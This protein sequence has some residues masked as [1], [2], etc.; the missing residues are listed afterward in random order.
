MSSNLHPIFEQLL[1]PIEPPHT[2]ERLKV[3]ATINKA[4]DMH[5]PDAGEAMDLIDAIAA[6]LQKRYGEAALEAAL[7]ASHL[8]KA[9][10][11]L[12][13]G[14]QTTFEQSEVDET[15]LDRNWR[16]RREP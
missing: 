1:K 6:G 11:R 8:Y 15:D 2:G 4:I 5:R 12:D 7:Y 16:A 10:E 3:F 13:S 14:V 9:L